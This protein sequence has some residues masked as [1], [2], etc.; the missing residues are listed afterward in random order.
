MLRCISHGWKPVVNQ[1]EIRPVYEVKDNYKS[2]FSF[3]GSVAK[4]FAKM[5]DNGVVEEVP[6]GTAGLWHPM[7]AV[8]KNSDR[9]KAGALA[10]IHITDQPSLEQASKALQE[11]GLP[12]IK[13]RI[14]HD[15]TAS[16]LNRAALCPPFRYPSSH[17]HC[18]Y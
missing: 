4:E 2:I 10:G 15:C 9:R 17:D 8:I 1:G 11:Q 16:G 5:V 13:A 12:A 6:E 7:G 3:A 18:S 14:T